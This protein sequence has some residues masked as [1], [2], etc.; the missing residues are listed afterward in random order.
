MAVL[1]DLDPGWIPLDDDPL[2]SRLSRL[3]WTNVPDGARA[4]C[5]AA[6]ASR[7]EATAA[8]PLDAQARDTG[9]RY[10]FRRQAALGRLPLA[11]A[12]ARRPGH[13]RGLSYA[14]PVLL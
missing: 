9:A 7:L 1:D 13:L 2:V 10:E 5:W 6:I 3:V 4:R 8:T 12:F 11:H 14:R